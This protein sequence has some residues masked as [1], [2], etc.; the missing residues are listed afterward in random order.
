MGE[1]GGAH[2]PAHLDELAL[3]QPS[4]WSHQT[5]SSGYLPV[6][7]DGVP[8]SNPPG[9]AGGDQLVTNEEER[10]CWHVQAEDAFREKRRSGKDPPGRFQM[11]QV[12]PN[13]FS[14]QSHSRCHLDRSP[15][16]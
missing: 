16:E 15:R 1:S 11:F 9:V 12:G 14:Y 4:I 7:G 2:T 5:G 10:L 3:G 13:I 6:F 8:H